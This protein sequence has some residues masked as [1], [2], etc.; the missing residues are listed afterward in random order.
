LSRP[1]IEDGMSN[2]L[3]FLRNLAFFVV[4]LGWQFLGNSAR[5]DGPADN[6][7]DKVRQIPPPGIAVPDDIRRDLTSRLEGLQE[8]IRGLRERISEDRKIEGLLPDIEIFSRAVD[9]AL[10]FSEFFNERDFEAAR[11]LLDEGAARAKALAQGGAPWTLRTGL[12]VRG[13]RSKLDD[14]V[15]PYGLLIPDEYRFEGELDVRCDIWLHGR[16]ENVVELQFIR[17]R[18]RN[19]GDIAPAKTIVLHPFGRFSNAFKFA[20]EVDVFEALDHAKANY[21]IDPNRVA[22]RGFSMG[23]AGCWQMAVHYPDRFFAANP[24]AGFSETPEFL[25]VFQNETLSS[26]SWEQA[27]WNWYDCPGW[28]G[29]LRMIPTVAYSGEDDRQKQAADV[30]A[31][32]CEKEGLRLT[33]LIG[34]KTG[35]QIHP[36]SK[37]EIE[38][39]LKSIERSHSSTYPWKV[40]YSTYSLRY[41][42]CDWLEIEGLEQHWK[43][44]GVHAEV[45]GRI[46]VVMASNITDVRLAFDAGSFTVDGGA[47]A[48]LHITSDGAKDQPIYD[49]PPALTDGSWE[50]SAHL[51]GGSWKLGR[52]PASGLRKRH[53]LQG[54]I[55]DAFMES[56]IFVRP[57]GKSANAAVDDWVTKELDHAIAHWRQQMRGDARVKLDSELTEDDVKRHNIVLWGT[58]ESNGVLKRIAGLLPAKWDGGNVGIGTASLSAESHV[59]LLIYPN[60]ENPNRYVVLN[61]SFTY[62][63]YDY[64]NNARQ[65]P[66]LPDWALIDIRVAPNSRYP[67]KVAAAGF[68]DEGW[69]PGKVL[70]GET[71]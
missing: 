30:M 39:R 5:A 29:N 19:R 68:F 64:L 27:L 21:R 59:P 7:I 71:P 14:T 41:N 2:R 43:Q 42:R 47:P 22:I 37:V 63:E 51:V 49:L 25:R 12:V 8:Q 50:I 53:G 6:A 26:P 3:V 10:R 20:G 45:L 15:Q 33:H 40:T 67:G 56:F 13:Y 69:Q 16:F 44:A 52:R 31:A 65:T 60:P 48:E 36:E 54:P 4:C 66:K 70:T 62:R 17:Q 1:R 9:Q 61:S 18:M 55:D 34:P 58:P 11:A 57:S 46:A 32:A 24:G 28:V 35:H 23:G 38:R